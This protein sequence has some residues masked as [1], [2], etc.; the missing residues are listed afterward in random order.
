MEQLTLINICLLIL[1]LL[2]NVLSY[3]K[4][5]KK[6]NKSLRLDIVDLISAVIGVLSAFAGLLLAKDLFEA[7][8]AVVPNDAPLYALHAFACGLFPNLIIDKVIKMTQK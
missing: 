1:G 3:Y 5:K 2:I 4:K 7:G 6:E 8:G